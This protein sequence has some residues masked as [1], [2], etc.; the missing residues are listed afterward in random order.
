MGI[1]QPLL[2]RRACSN[3]AHACFQEAASFGQLLKRV[4][5]ARYERHF[6]CRRE[7]GL[8]G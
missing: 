7:E 2:K 6:V 3:S 4:A 1:V 5:R 8:A